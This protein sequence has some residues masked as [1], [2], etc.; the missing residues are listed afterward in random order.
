MVFAMK[1]NC[2][3]DTEITTMVNTYRS[4]VFEFTILLETV[5][6]VGAH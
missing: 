5:K 4:I 3:V 2:I 1:K 6:E